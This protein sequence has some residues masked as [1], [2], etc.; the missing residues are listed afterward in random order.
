MKGR[1]IK[2]F[3]G[4]QSNVPLAAAGE[5]FL[6]YGFTYVGTGTGNLAGLNDTFYFASSTAGDMRS[7]NFEEP[8]ELIGPVLLTI[9]TGGNLTL[10]G[11]VLKEIA[12]GKIGTN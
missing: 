1:P 12:T 2:S 5:K 4:A 7:E 11:K 8:I 6:L 3:T 9:T 10:V